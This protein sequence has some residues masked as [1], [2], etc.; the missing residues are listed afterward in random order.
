MCLD[1]Y[2]MVMIIILLVCCFLM[3]CLLVLGIIEFRKSNKEF[4]ALV[5]ERRRMNEQLLKK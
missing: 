4:E 1:N 5:S 3:I 2:E